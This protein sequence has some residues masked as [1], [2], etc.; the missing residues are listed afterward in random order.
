[1]ITHAPP[2]TRRLTFFALLNLIL[3]ISRSKLKLKLCMPLKLSTTFVTFKETC[4]QFLS[5]RKTVANYTIS[6][7]CKE[8]H[9]TIVQGKQNTGMDFIMDVQKLHADINWSNGDINYYNFF[10]PNICHVCKSKNNGVLILCNKCYMI[11]YCSERHKQKDWEEHQQ[12][13]AYITEFVKEN[14][15]MKWRFCRLETPEWIETRRKFLYVITQRFPRSLE[16]YEIQMITFAKSCLICHQQ[17]NIQ[18]CIR[19]YSDNF[20]PIHMEVFFNNHASKCGELMLCL[21][22]DILNII[23]TDYKRLIEFP[24][25]SI[26][27]DNMLEFVLNCVYC[28][29]RNL[30]N[31]NRVFTKFAYFCSDYVSGPFTLFDGMRKAQLL[32]LPNM[33]GPQCVIHVISANTIENKYMKAWELLHHLL[34]RIKKLTIVLIGE[35]LET[36]NINLESCDSC[37]SRN[38]RINVVC[39]PGSYQEYTS[40]PMFQQPNIIVIFQAHFDTTNTWQE[41]S[42][43]TPQRMNCPYILT[44]G[45]QSI[46]VENI[47]NIQKIININ[48][49]Y[50][51]PNNFKSFYPCRQLHTDNV[52]YRNSHITVYRN[53]YLS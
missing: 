32:D 1:M 50:N 5:V 47:I 26:L 19:C 30:D 49:V 53:L 42:L 52:G 35:E 27:P 41:D 14:S 9:L 7:P 4:K 39:R 29:Y 8:N 48:P 23:P 43:L 22:L 21:N 20:C 11:S 33:A 15:S 28:S 38:Q 17:I 6:K 10:H 16:Q 37:K 2:G 13:C 36:Q 25:K 45:S 31:C 3:R 12:F 34:Y 44:A 40:D 18:P 24:N 51:K 46:A